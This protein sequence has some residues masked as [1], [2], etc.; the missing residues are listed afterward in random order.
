MK[1]RKI[2][3]SICFAS[4]FLA[5]TVMAQ[6][7]EW[8]KAYGGTGFTNGISMVTDAIGNVYT[9]GFFSGTVDFHPDSSIL[10]N[11]TSAAGSTYINKFDADGNFIWVKI[12]E[13][14]YNV[15]ESITLDN[16]DNIL[17]TGFFRSTVDFYP[18]SNIFNLTSAGNNDVYISKL[19]ANG[20]FIAAI[21]LGSTNTEE[22]QSI[23]VDSSNNIYI[24]GIFEGTTDFDPGS[25]VYNLF[26]SGDR[27]I[28]I[29]KL[30]DSGNFIWAKSV[31][32]T[33]VKTSNSI[34]TDNAGNIY[35]R[36]RYF[37]IKIKH[38][39]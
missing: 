12:F 25:G 33:S 6:S 29:L 36:C 13:G 18:G 17:I 9:T 1:A 37:Y 22:P 8:A 24:S 30:D 10:Y 16:N 3:Y 32:G 38:F 4:V 19:D 11:L 5:Q 23:C 15:P 20:D 14:G 27:D 28:F 7:F 35:G 39:G 21:R 26:S 31:S 34:K 2:I